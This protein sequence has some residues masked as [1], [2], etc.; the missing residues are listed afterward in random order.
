MH[1][2]QKHI[3]S[4]DCSSKP[5]GTEVQNSLGDLMEKEFYPKL[6]KLLDQYPLAN[7]TWILEKIEIILPTISKKNWKNE[8]VTNALN[9]I[10]KFLNSNFDNGNNP[11]IK[12]YFDSN[13]KVLLNSNYA[14]FLFFEYLRTGLLNQNSLFKSVLDIEQQLFE[15]TFS[16][17]QRKKAFCE[18]LVKVIS[19]KQQNLIRFIYTISS[20][21]RTVL[22][23]ERIGFLFEIAP[24]LKNEKFGLKL[25]S[26]SQEY[27]NWLSLFE[28][29]LYLYET[30]S[31]NAIYQF[32]ESSLLNFQLNAPQIIQF[33]DVLIHLSKDKIV[34]SHLE[35]LLVFNEKIK[36]YS[37]NEINLQ[38]E[39]NL[40]SNSIND[41]RKDFLT[42]FEIKNNHQDENIDL[43]TDI[44]KEINGP[45]KEIELLGDKEKNSLKNFDGDS[46]S[47]SKLRTTESPESIDKIASHLNIIDADNL[48]K[49]TLI[50]NESSAV[51]AKI[52]DNN[53]QFSNEFLD[54]TFKDNIK[55]INATINSSSIDNTE[56]FNQENEFNT[57]KE[58]TSLS[59]YKSAPSLKNI[60][61]SEKI[62]PKLTYRRFN[63]D[64]KDSDS[65]LIDSNQAIKNTKL[66][67]ENPIYIEN[68]GL[69][70]LHP[71]LIHLFEQLKLCNNEKW[72]SK[73]NQYKAV[74]LTQYL[75]TGNTVFFENQLVL[76]KLLCGL[77]VDA[78]IDLTVK[79]SRK[80]INEAIGLL[81][82]VIGYWVI[83][84]N[85]SIEG[86]RE[87]FLQRNGKLL[88]KNEETIELWVE[89]KGVDVLMAQIPWGIG[90]IK[91]PWMKHFLECNWNR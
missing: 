45:I 20:D 19:E 69:I 85:S 60:K 54:T 91:T 51:E 89:N 86:L 25:F 80:D 2:I 70:I 13:N 14:E 59:E 15:Q 1:Q 31:K 62:Y 28:W 40:F 87:T 18:E 36:E 90:M 23:K 53:T 41:Q 30:N 74:L 77:E 57:D 33:F 68:S 84:K 35:M 66:I 39:T 72:T 82:A 34:S 29:S 48:K 4:I 22:K 6:E 78:V 76:N 16:S 3:I 44:T 10:E 55:E 56:S 17:L 61:K 8:L 52:N 12:K 21:M 71:F 46:T 73:R 7:A 50:E 63:L 43:L 81:K 83:L 67:L 38:T 47:S 42:D 37:A 26:S 64:E 58:K 65:K 88:F 27:S 9:E 79:L 75:I 32:K 11:Q 5:D 24:L 49:I